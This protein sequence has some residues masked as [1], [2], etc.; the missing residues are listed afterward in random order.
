[1]DY[2]MHH[3]HPLPRMRDIARQMFTEADGGDPRG[4]RGG[5]RGHRG[6][7][8]R[9]GG[10]GFGPMSGFGAGFGSGFG[11]GFPGG[12]GRGGRRRRGDVRLAALLLIAETP[13][14]GYQI[15]QELA[16]RTD[17]HWKPSPGAIYPALS[18]LEDEG[19]IRA[20]DGGK[21]YEVTDAGRAE[22]AAVADQPAPWEQAGDDQDP[23]RALAHSMRQAAQAVGAIVQS[24]DAEL[25]T[26]ATAELDDLKRKL[27]Q[28]LAE[29]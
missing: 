25:I 22:A 24:G 4:R 23:A 5:P 14:N 29:A 27:Y 19:L 8:G 26:K 10:P 18:Q 12:P 15:I 21:V 16:A 20:L 1:M 17:G 9:E 13:R 3:P 2:A 7:G 11:H 28:L 6:P